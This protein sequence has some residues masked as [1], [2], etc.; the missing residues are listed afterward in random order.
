MKYLG[1]HIEFAN[2]SGKETPGKQIVIHL[3]ENSRIREMLS[4]TLCFIA[5]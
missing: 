3:F 4:T 2:A 5:F 1:K